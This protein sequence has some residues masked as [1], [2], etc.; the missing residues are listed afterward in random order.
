MR[1]NWKHA[2]PAWRAATSPVADEPERLPAVY[3]ALKRV[4]PPV[5]R[6]FFAF[7]VSG[8]EHVPEQGPFIVAA[9]HANYLDGVVLATAL[10]RKISFL[11]MPRVYRATPLHPYFHDHVGSIP[12]S[13]ARPDPG[14]HP[15][16][17]AGPRAGRRGGHLPGG[18]VQP[19]R[20]PRPRPARRRPGRAPVRR[21]RRPRRH[22]GDVPG[23]GR[24]ALLRPPPGAARAS[25]S[26]SP[27][28]SRGRGSGRP[29]ASAPTSP[30]GSWRRSRRCWPRTRSRRLGGRPAMTGPAP[31]S[32]WGGRFSEPTD[33]SARAFTASLPFDHRL[34]PHDIRGSEA[35]ARALAKGGVLAEAE[36]DAILRGLA[37]VRGGARDR[38]L[39]VPDRARGH[40]HEHRAAPD[41]EDRRRRREAPHRPLAQRPD[42]A[43]HAALAPGGDRRDPPRAPRRPGRAPGAGRA[44]P[45]QPDAG[46]HPPPAGAARAAGPPPPGVR[47]HA[48]AGPRAVRRRAAA[49]RRVPARRRRPCGHHGAHRPPR[50]RPGARLP[51]PRRRTA[52]TPCRTATSRWSSAR[53]PRSRPPTCRGSPRSSSCGPR[54]SSASSS[55]PTPTP[56]DRRSCRRRRTRT[57]PS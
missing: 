16:G 19:V 48:G 36:L 32:P 17:A 47:L 12:V 25:A 42:R 10:P 39:P 41:R 26:G 35:W 27:S 23:P 38:R 8:L 28:A 14:R 31:K 1:P 30:A 57:S 37:E 46:L 33:T 43:R 53:R 7:R 4:L 55:S 56:P 49:P 52:W 2:P 51:T 44:A 5:L 45:D 6:R 24:P 13:L 15:P 20:A 22:L 29:R 21:S 40:P 11:V 54:P 34:W 18:P 50:A 3:A 9:N